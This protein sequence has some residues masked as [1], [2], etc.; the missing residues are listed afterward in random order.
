MLICRE[1]FLCYGK[2][3]IQR[4]VASFNAVHDI[5]SAA[6][7][8]QCVRQ[9]VTAL[10]LCG[11]VADSYAHKHVANLHDTVGRAICGNFLYSQPFHNF[12]FTRVFV[13]D[14]GNGGNFNGYSRYGTH[15]RFA[16]IVSAV[17]Q[18]I[19]GNSL[20]QIGR[21]GVADIFGGVGVHF[22]VYQTD[23]FA[24]RIEKTSAG[25][26]GIYCSVGCASHAK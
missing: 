10:Y 13:D 15:Y 19:V 1:A 21:N 7:V 14:G 9:V 2:R 8:E 25:V 11:N 20:H 23:K 24:L 12:Y 5:L 26:A 18:N 6:S 22:G 16:G 3:Q 17:V 4:F